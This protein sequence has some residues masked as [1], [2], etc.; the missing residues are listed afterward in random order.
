MNRQF[1]EVLC[2][3]KIYKKKMKK[4]NSASYEGIMTFK[5]IQLTQ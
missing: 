2:K 5:K 3:V 4:K 1:I